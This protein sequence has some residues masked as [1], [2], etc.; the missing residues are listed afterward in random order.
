[1]NDDS[2]QP[3][4][5]WGLLAA[6]VYNLTWGSWVI[7]RPNDLFDWTG[8]PR[9][10]YAGIWQCVGMIVG[11]YGIGYLIAARDPLR[12]WPIVLVG[13]LGKIF[14]P[15]GMFQNWLIVPPGTSGRFPASWFWLNVTNDLIWWV[16]FG[17]ILYAAFRKWNAPLDTSVLSVAQANEAAMTQYRQSLSEVTQQRAALVVFLRHRG[18]TFCRQMLSQ[19][20]ERRTEIEASTTIVLI[21]MGD[22][23]DQ[24]QA[25]FDSFGLGDVARISDP[26]TRLYRAYGIPRGKVR[27]LFGPSV[28]WR[29]FKAAILQRH[30]VGGLGGDGFQLSGAFVVRDN[31]IISGEHHPTA[32]DGSDYCELA[33]QAV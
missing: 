30:A 8:I 1:M 27:Q 14:G 29:G 32:A 12:H 28:W 3:W 5:K 31:E 21:H 23:D 26:Q 19:I 22:E 24:S 9:P 16:P 18:C 4:M 10:V 15:I 20:A 25:Y 13:L 7:F 11:V 17:A 33:K 6:G 2:Y